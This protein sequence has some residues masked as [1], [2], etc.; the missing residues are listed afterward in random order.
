MLKQ[1]MKELTQIIGVS[2]D[3]KRVSRYL[4]EQYNG[5]CDTIVY[6]NLGSI[7]AVKKSKK[8]NAPR[9][10]VCGFLNACCYIRLVSFAF[11]VN[12]DTKYKHTTAYRNFIQ[13]K[14]QIIKYHTLRQAIC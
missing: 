11:F 9:V 1:W 10:M 4:S 3:E 13:F 8:E 7:F 12:A 6:D 14:P 5:L 2:G